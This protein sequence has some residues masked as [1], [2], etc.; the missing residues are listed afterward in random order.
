MS[1][2]EETR[3]SSTVNLVKGGG[4][5]SGSTPLDAP[6]NA[7]AAVRPSLTASV[8]LN[9]TP[10]A[11]STTTEPHPRVTSPEAT[12][13]RAAPTGPVASHP[14]GA[15]PLLPGSSRFGPGLVAGLAVGV[16]A[17]VVVVILAFGGSSPSSS[18]TT[19][20]GADGTVSDVA[21]EPDDAVGGD[22]TGLS[23]TALIGDLQHLGE[24]AEYGRR[25]SIS[26]Q[27][28]AAAD[29]RRSI[30][31]ALDD[32]DGQTDDL[33]GLRAAFRS[34]MIASAQA[35]ERTLS[36]GDDALSSCSQPYHQRAHDLKNRFRK[37]FFPYEREAGLS[38]LRENDF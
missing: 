5:R 11:A 25:L 17:V 26:H 21:S 10:A 1:S 34:A 31:R 33:P 20:G 4:T 36:C 27:W 12:S 14:A 7:S 18:T 15:P 28:Q 22:A 16:I 3:T 24:R 37:L 35:N 6:A 29:N 2:T 13:E 8:P 23:R 30:V 32:L 9:G 19:A 38:P